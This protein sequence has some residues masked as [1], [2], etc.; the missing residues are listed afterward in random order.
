MKL[1]TINPAAENDGLLH[2]TDVMNG[3]N[4]KRRK[5]RDGR[6]TVTHDTDVPL[7]D[8]KLKRATITPAHFLH[9]HTCGVCGIEMTH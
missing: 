3:K 8:T 5:K 2:T 1:M 4:G 9:R 7:T 6:Q